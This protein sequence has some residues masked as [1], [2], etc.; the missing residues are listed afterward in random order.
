MNAQ[1]KVRLS[2]GDRR[3]LGII[4]IG[5]IA[6]V[7]LLILLALGF[8]PQRAT[9]VR[10]QALSPLQEYEEPS[11]SLEEGGEPSSSLEGEA[12]PRVSSYEEREE[13]HCIQYAGSGVAAEIGA[14]AGARVA[15]VPLAPP[16][17]ESGPSGKIRRVRDP[18]PRITSGA[19]P[20]CVGA[21]LL[22]KLHMNRNA[23]IVSGAPPLNDE[24]VT[25][26]TF[27]AILA[28]AGDER[29]LRNRISVPAAS[30][31][32]VLRKI[33]FWR[34]PNRV[35]YETFRATTISHSANLGF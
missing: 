8:G 11:L 16:I 34:P 12:L 17:S 20:V 27:Q 28:S 19:E 1:S 26:V 24:Q 5:G 3:M 6:V 31:G 10:T 4:F 29:A 14:V 15:Q 23:D 33:Q 22:Q 9:D 25:E 18:D 13:V 2:G 32:P 21:S 7:I 30:M 35:S